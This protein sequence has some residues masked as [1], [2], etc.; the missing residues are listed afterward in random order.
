MALRPPCS[1]ARQPAWLLEAQEEMRSLL[2]ADVCKLMQVWYA[3]LVRECE[4]SDD[5][6]VL[7]ANTKHM[8]NNGTPSTPARCWWSLWWWCC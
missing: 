2:W 8:C 5:D 7:D 3:K 1:P 6:H 4:S